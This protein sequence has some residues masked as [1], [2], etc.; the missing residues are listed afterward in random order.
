MI[1]LIISY[2]FMGSLII[3]YML[4]EDITMREAFKSI[5]I[6]IAWIFW[7]I[8]LTWGILKSIGVHW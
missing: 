6:W 5:R 7:P 3:A 8:T 4:P 1:W 2:L